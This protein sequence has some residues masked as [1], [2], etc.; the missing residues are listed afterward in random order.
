MKAVV[1][2]VMRDFPGRIK[3]LT[4]KGFVRNVA[5]IATGAALAQGLTLLTSPLLTRLFS[6]EAFGFLGVFAAVTGILGP[7]T[8]LRYELAIPVARTKRMASALLYLCFTCAAVLAALAA[9]FA[10]LWATDIAA[11]LAS[12]GLEPYLILLPVHI[13]AMGVFLGLSQ[14]AV[15][16]KHFSLMARNPLTRA[17]VT[18]GVQLGSGL[19]ALGQ[20][21]L[22]FGVLAGNVAAALGLAGRLMR[23]EA[24]AL[25]APRHFRAS[26]IAAARRFRRF[27]V[28]SAPQALINA[29]SQQLPNLVLAAFFGPAIVGL[30]WLT[31]RI[32]QA[33]SNLVGQAVRQVFYQRVCDLLNHGDRPFPL[34]A[35]TTGAL[36]L[37][38]AVAF[39]PVIAFGPMLFGLVFG[40]NWR[41]A[42][43]FA[44][45]VALWSW[46]GFANVPAVCGLQAI[47]AQRALLIYE[48]LLF[49]GR[50]GVMAWFAAVGQPLEAIA[51]FALVGVAFNIGLIGYGH[52]Q[53]IT[54]R[55]S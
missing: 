13:L 53:A 51:A 54:N 17:V 20:G 1:S 30:Y 47:G 46:V 32:L 49:I 14:W 16:R 27:P 36:F 12:P 15:R 52:W 31:I 38:G 2:R 18:I 37:V 45:W 35:K 34:M 9:L 19:A 48:I 8:A 7:A 21:W 25:R 11:L 44:R 28:F 50:N 24:E 22:I 26:L 55:Q 4:A 43:E 33:P 23:L 6:P 42:G 29:L 10:A 5:M 41:E 3:C 40:D 39:L